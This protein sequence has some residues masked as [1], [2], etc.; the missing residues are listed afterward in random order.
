MP[1]LPEDGFPLPPATTSASVWADRVGPR[2]YVGRTQRGVEIPIGEG[3]HEINPG[4]LL[5]LALLGCAGMSAD[6]NLSR[7]LGDG[8]PMRLWAH[9][10]SDPEQNRYT[11]IGEE[12]QLA[13][14]DLEPEARQ[15]VVT[16]LGRAIAAGCTV[17][18]SVV[19][20]IEVTHRVL[21]AEDGRHPQGPAAE[22]DFER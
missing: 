19:P 21:G 10:A 4:E 5:K 3:E 9:D 20:G 7:R 16:V 22:E 18:R 6:V 17:E 12:I 11:R 1:G 2:S 13:L 14:E 15:K 8:F